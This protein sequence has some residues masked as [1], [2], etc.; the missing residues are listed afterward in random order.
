MD[1]DIAV[2][3]ENMPWPSK[4]RRRDFFGVLSLFLFLVFFVVVVGFV[5]FFCLFIFF[6]LS[7]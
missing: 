1:P 6:L 5:I 7:S 2:S 4:Q 3:C